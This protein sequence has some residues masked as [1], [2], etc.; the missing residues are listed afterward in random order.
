MTLGKSAHQ[1]G[2]SSFAP[3]PKDAPHFAQI[4]PSVMP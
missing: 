3:Q 4:F 2:F 1:Q